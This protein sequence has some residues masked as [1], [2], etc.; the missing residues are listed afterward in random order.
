[1]VYG[2]TIDPCG[3][4]DVV[5]KDGGTMRKSA[6]LGIVLLVAATASAQTQFEITPFVGYQFGGELATGDD[7]PVTHD[8]DQAPT[9]PPLSTLIRPLTASD[10]RAAI[11]ASGFLVVFLKPQKCR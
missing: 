5:E 8:L 4:S 3:L 10:T 6:L 11:N 9:W 7:E 2:R 1:M